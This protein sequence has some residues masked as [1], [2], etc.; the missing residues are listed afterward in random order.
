MQR[1]IEKH[2]K[3]QVVLIERLSENQHFLRIIRKLRNQ[4]QFPFFV[5]LQLIQVFGA[6]LFIAVNQTAYADRVIHM[7]ASVG[8][9]DDRTAVVIDSNAV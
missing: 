8:A 3:R 4:S 5:F 1:R 6:D 9:Y 2:I 7:G